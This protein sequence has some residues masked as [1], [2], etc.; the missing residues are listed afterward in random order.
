MTKI[1]QR[2]DQVIGFVQFDLVFYCQPVHL[3]MLQIPRDENTVSV[4][5]SYDLYTMNHLLMH[6]RAHE[7]EG[8]S[9]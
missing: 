3:S 7:R 8:K 5:I 2:D 6:M 1:I 4:N 9:Y